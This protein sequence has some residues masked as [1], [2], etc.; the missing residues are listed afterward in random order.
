MHYFELDDPTAQ[1][2]FWSRTATLDW[3]EE[4][5]VMCTYIAEFWNTVTNFSFI[6]LSLYGMY[7]VRRYN[8]ELRFFIA[9]AGLCLVGVGS[10]LFHM[11]LRYEMQLLDE[12]PMIYCTC[13]LTY[14][15]FETAKTSRFGWKLPII[16]LVDAALVT[17]LYLY[18]KNPIFHQI[19][20]AAQTAVIVFRGAYLFHKLPDSPTKLVMSRLLRTGWGL[21]ALGF[22]LWNVDNQFCTKIRLLRALLPSPLA[23]L[24]QFHAWWHLLTC[25]GSYYYIVFIQYMHTMMLGKEEEYCVL[26]RFSCVPCVAPRPSLK[27]A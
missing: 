3:C 26:W 4:N 1:Q 19:A 7:C 25:A 12:L 13:V 6:F 27:V 10:W 17:V 15:I 20:Y 23:T 8:F 24:L 14:I 11:T 9:Y 22:F 16:L 18:S 5:Y 21:F 2:D